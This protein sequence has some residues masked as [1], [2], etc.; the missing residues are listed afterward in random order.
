MADQEL[1]HKEKVE[2]LYANTA[3]AQTA[4]G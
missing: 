3:F 2:Y 4:G 1:R